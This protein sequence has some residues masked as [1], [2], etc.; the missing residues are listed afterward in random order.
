MKR[1]LSGLLLVW[2]CLIF[3][4]SV[5]ASEPTV[6][7]M[8]HGGEGVNTGDTS[9][10]NIQIADPGIQ[11]LDMVTALSMNARAAGCTVN[12]SGVRNISGY[13]F[14]IDDE[15]VLL[16]NVDQFYTND[17]YFKIV[18]CATPEAD[19]KQAKLIWEG[20]FPKGE[21]KCQ[22]RGSDSYIVMRW[23]N[24]VSDAY[25]NHYDLKITLENIW[26]N[27]P[28]TQTMYNFIIAEDWSGVYSGLW[29]IAGCDTA[30]HVGSYCDIK[31]NV[32]FSGTDTPVYD[33]K[34]LFG[35]LDLDVR[36]IDD[37]FGTDPNRYQESIQ[38]RDGLESS[39]YVDS[40]HV[41][42]IDTSRNLFMSTMATDRESEIKAGISFL[43]DAGETKVTWCG[44][45]CG[46]RMLFKVNDWL[47]S[48]HIDPSKEG[49]GT[50]SPSSRVGAFSGQN[51]SFVMQADTGAHIT[52]F[53]VD[54]VSQTITNTTRM[55][56]TFSNIRANHTIHVEF[57]KDPV[58]AKT[59]IRWRKVDGTWE[60]Y[61]LADSAD[62]LYGDAYAYTWVRG[63]L[64]DESENVYYDANPCSVSEIIT[65]D[66]SFY[67]DVERKKYS[68]TFDY[69]PP[70]GYAVIGIGNKQEDLLDRWA[71]T[72]S[73]S[74][75]SPEL[76]GYTFLGWNTKR[77]VSGDW[78][79]SESMLSNKTFYAIW[80]K[81]K[82]KVHYDSNGSSNPDHQTGEFTQNTVTGSMLD[83]DYEYD[84]KGK[85]RTNAFVRKGYAF[86]GWNTKADGSG[87][88]YGESS[89][90]L[91][92]LYSD[93]YGNVYNMT[94]VDGQTLTLY[95]QWKKK[96]GTE[97]LTVISEETG[98]PVAGVQVKLYQKVNGSWIERMDVGVQTTDHNG[99][100]SV[101]NLH[102]FAYE[103]RS[104][105]VPDGYQGMS[106]VSYT[107][108]W[109][110]LDLIH[111]RIL[112]LKRVTIVL[113]SRVS[114]RIAGEANPS[115]VYTVS[116]TDAAGVR[117]SY[118]VSVLVED[119][120]NGF[121]E[122]SGIYAGMYDVTQKPVMRYQ[123]LPAENVLHSSV[124]GINGKA[125]VLQYDRAELRFPYR[126]LQ[127]EGFGSMDVQENGFMN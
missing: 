15:Y 38:I 69:N 26:Y 33:G 127:Y 95:A 122:L 113:Y 55:E 91:A 70:D 11:I 78:Y 5:C 61:S 92:G 42:Y 57:E 114:E 8:D 4:L 45:S 32:L 40:D 53:L 14:L 37:Y 18:R 31:Y 115:F 52:K 100:V 96:L 44:T 74:V 47:T 77:D 81:N 63:N 71:E 66:S 93:G 75:K 28:L 101:G 112:Y 49:P 56:Y 34:T 29:V 104:V 90:D 50:I 79:Q 76:T 86:V 121:S 16:S 94:S 13:D 99:Q 88:A 1:W 118:E 43:G 85:L 51:R 111:E 68:Y 126:L 3:S 73:G 58:S 9:E 30:G 108:D 120:R 105:S 117:H 35:Y 65:S 27:N 62:L 25:N 89:Y 20:V 87:L 119:N 123:A 46:T 60:P 124:L 106:D 110:H 84:T 2:M 24:A 107:V 48:Y 102:W 10:S 21:A 6:V 19:S 23:K 54:G 109:D 41:L 98:N 103:W 82:Y 39:V 17:P 67:L 83:S 22:Y 36:N 12:T 72:V 80:R 97:K 59:Y 64:R 125:N 116:G 7:C